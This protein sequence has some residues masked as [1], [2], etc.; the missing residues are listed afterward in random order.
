ML[1]KDISH[2]GGCPCCG[3]RLVPPPCPRSGS[4]AFVFKKMPWKLSSHLIIS[5][6]QVGVRDGANADVRW[7]HSRPK[8]R[9][10]YP[11]R[12]KRRVETGAW[13]DCGV[14]LAPLVFL[15]CCASY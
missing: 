5:W 11:K 10:F 3:A 7:P 15:T 13:G 6:P 9:R 1:H 14:T 12:Q 8:P 4:S 2:F